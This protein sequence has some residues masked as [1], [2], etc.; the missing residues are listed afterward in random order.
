MD[1]TI[2]RLKQLLDACIASQD[3]LNAE[4]AKVNHPAKETDS[5]PANIPSDSEAVSYDVVIPDDHNIPKEIGTRIGKIAQKMY[6]IYTDADIDTRTKKYDTPDYV[7]KFESEILRNSW[8]VY[9]NNGKV[10]YM[11]KRELLA[12]SP[13]LEIYDIRQ[14]QYVA[15]IKT[16]IN[17]NLH[18]YSSFSW[19]V[20]GKPIGKVTQ[21]ITLKPLKTDYTEGSNG[22]TYS[23]GLTQCSEILCGNEI[24]AKPLTSR[25]ADP[26]PFEYYDL[27]NELGIVMMFYTDIL[28][29]HEERVTLSERL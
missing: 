21:K 3:E 18:L 4:K 7:M 5:I 25:V 15:T 2:T 11:V 8:K 19:V 17:Y 6:D 27:K 22:W 23:A 1:N 20:Q 9:D 28:N 12:T 13:S 10:I 29:S 16:D 24:I 26:M 14:G